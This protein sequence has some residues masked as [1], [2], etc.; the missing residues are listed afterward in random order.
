MLASTNGPLLLTGGFNFHLDVPTDRAAI[1]FMGLIE[2]FNLI[3]HVSASTH[4]SGHTLDLVITKANDNFIKY[5]EV[6]DPVISD[7]SAVHCGLSIKKLQSSTNL[8]GRFRQ[9]ALILRIPL[10]PFQCWISIACCKRIPV[11]F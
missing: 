1:R 4:K 11:V 5:I 2:A 8:L 10:P 7:H 3:Q 6:S 9:F